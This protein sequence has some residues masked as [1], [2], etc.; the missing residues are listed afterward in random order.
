MVKDIAGAYNAEQK[1]YKDKED[2][3]SNILN[4]I[5][6]IQPFGYNNYDE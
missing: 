5:D 6:Y 2:L 1:Y 4:V 3:Q